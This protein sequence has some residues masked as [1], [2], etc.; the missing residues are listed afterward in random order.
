M[1]HLVN[2]AALE[3]PDGAPSG[4]QYPCVS[5]ATAIVAPA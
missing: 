5:S 2:P 3:S 4:T 1:E